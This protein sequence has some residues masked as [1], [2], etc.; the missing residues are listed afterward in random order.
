M[1][2]YF[3]RCTYRGTDVGFSFDNIE[4]SAYILDRKFDYEKSIKVWFWIVE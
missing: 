1:L 2:E 3:P 4:V